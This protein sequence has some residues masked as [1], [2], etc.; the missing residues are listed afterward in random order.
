MKTT[1]K[2]FDAFKQHFIM[3][4]N[5]LGLTDIHI[6]FVHEEEESY[7]HVIG[8][9]EQKAYV[10]FLSKTFIDMEKMPKGFMKYLAFHEACECLLYGV[11]AIASD[12]EFNENTLDSEIHSIINRLEKIFVGDC[13][14]KVEVEV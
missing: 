4:I 8:N 3:W 9:I 6:N 7:A 13:N 2:D 10:V 1:K 12:R 5:K 14:F 11:R